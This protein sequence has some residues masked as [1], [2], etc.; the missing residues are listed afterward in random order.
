MERFD[1]QTEGQ[2]K[3]G[4]SHQP[5]VEG[6]MD[7]KP[8]H[9]DEDYRSGDKLKGK[10]ALITGADS[11]IGRSVAIGYAKEGADVA[12]SYL[13]EHQDAEDTAKLIE[14]E[15]QKALLLPG[16]VGD[17][18]H[19]KNIVEKTLSEFGKL[20]VLVNNAAEQHPTDDLLNISAEQLEQTFRTNI[21]SMFHLTKAA[22]PHLERGS[23]IINTA[24]INPYTG[25]SQLVD[26]T[27]SKGAV[28]AF[29]R[30]MAQQLVNKGIRVNGVAPGPIWTPLIPA[31][32]DEDKVEQFGTNTPMGRPGQPVEHVGSY[33]LL[34]SDD[35]TYMTGQ[36]IHINGGLYMS[37]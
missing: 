7:P 27:S 13:E 19:C 17:E 3:Q 8:L 9:A 34:A 4:Q 31:T 6:K 21:F 5:G 18:T 36:F 25:N 35:S 32:F 14:A 11:G 28:V 33:V 16:D 10:V 26:Y 30:S 12:I 23:S 29:T 20:D 15:G 2:P 37:S 22:I 1:R 24:S